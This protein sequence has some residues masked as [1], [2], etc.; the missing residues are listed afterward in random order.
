MDYGKQWPEGTPQL[1][2]ELQGF[3]AN[4]KIDGFLSRYEHALNIIRLQWPDD[5]VLER[6]V[7]EK[8]YE[9]TYFKRVLRGCCEHK[10]LGLTGSAST[11]KTFTCAVYALIAFW[12]NPG[13]TSIIIS[14][15][16]GT[17]SDRRIWG[18]IKD[19]YAKAEFKIGSPVDYLKCIVFDPGKELAGKKDMPS[20][21][22][23]NGIMVVPIGRGAEG[24]GALRTLIGTKNDNVVWIIDE[25]PEM[26]E[27]IFEPRYNLASNNYFQL[28]GIGNAKSRNDPHGIFCEPRDGW[29]TEDLDGG[30]WITKTGYCIFLDGEKSP[31]M[32]PE[33]LGITEKSKLP[34][35]K[36]INHISLAEMAY[37]AGSGDPNQGRQTLQYLRMGRGIWPDE[38][39]ENTVL[40]RNIITHYHANESVTW[41]Y[42]Q[43]IHLC[44]CDPSF[45]SDGDNFALMF[46]TLGQTMEGDI[47]LL[48]DQ[49]VFT[50]PGSKSKGED[51]HTQMATKVINACERR[52]VLPQYFSIDASHDGGL[53]GQAIMRL[54]KSNDI[55]LL[56][57]LGRPQDRL[58]YDG[59][60]RKQ[61]EVY[62]RAV[63][64]YWYNVRRG[65]MSGHIKGFNPESRYAF[66][67]FRRRY[68]SLKNNKVSVETKT[69]MK[70]R[71][72]RSPD[73]GDALSYLVE[74]ALQNG[75]DFNYDPQAQSGPMVHP[76]QFYSQSYA[77]EEGESSNDVWE[78]EYGTFEEVFE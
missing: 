6:E 17:A 65:V 34:F 61:T 20:R 52:G 50:I 26:D 36:I 75:L 69:E 43:I 19:L 7:G 23:R 5:V 40:S 76:D 25:L 9:N 72:K 77:Y 48:L 58:V 78:E 39:I 53:M 74:I 14:T 63:T 42:K 67:M 11:G 71:L 32:H 70:K 35:P 18:D 12:A 49:D 3:A 46:G 60:Y 62:D 56:S 24:A 51:F 38:S 22:V 64:A 1:I 27:G 44:G 66:D 29:G 73:Y 4:G 30:E 28:I 8:L 21:D 37:S 10:T 59:D 41:N 31:N 68:V 33:L 45:S 55:K 54:W 57:S 16:S 2:K 15:T 13:A 47:K